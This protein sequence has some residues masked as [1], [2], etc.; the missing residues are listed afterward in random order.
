V[1]DTGIGIPLGSRHRLFQ[2]F[3]QIDASTTR[4]FG[5]TGLGLAISKRLCELMGGT[6]DVES[7]PGVGSTFHFT[8]NLGIPEPNQPATQNG[9]R[10]SLTGRRFLVVD[11]NA[12]N[13]LILRLYLE[14]W[15]AEC[16]DVPSAE[17]A[18]R[19]LGCDGRFDAFL[20]DFQMPDC[21]GLQLAA[22]LREQKVGAPIVVLTSGSRE[23][24][25]E[26]A[27]RTS[28]NR[29]LEKPIKPL[30]LYHVLT[31]ELGGGR[32]KE[33]EAG[34]ATFT[35]IA[36][37]HPLSILLAE[38]NSVNQLVAQRI[39]GRLGYRVD[40][41]ANGAEVLQAFR[42]RSYEV[43]LMDVQ[44]PEMDGVQATLELRSR[45]EI[46]QPWIIAMTASA[47]SGDRERYLSAG[48]N[49]YVAKPVTIQDVAEA[50]KRAWTQAAKPEEK[51]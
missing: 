6:M 26:R 37:A 22:K 15:G 5:G 42:Q 23:E 21:D 13:R 36:S 45:P 27:E 32:P 33:G 28:V 49:D 20:L 29:V 9:T 34:G 25:R 8:V 46:K 30:T 1:R 43:V 24:I 47:M 39:L 48:M 16:V 10:G 11:D 38:D 35:R 50:L 51:P 7:T 3:S 19:R 31:E 40:T 41:V 12:T 14:G 4:Q 17:A 2:Y 18:L 44:M